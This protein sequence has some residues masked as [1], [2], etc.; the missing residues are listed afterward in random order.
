M[1]QWRN[2][3]EAEPLLKKITRTFCQ[4]CLYYIG[5]VAQTEAQWRNGAMAQWRNGAMAKWRNGAEAELDSARAGCQ[6]CLYY[7]GVDLEQ[8][9]EKVVCLYCF[10]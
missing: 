7:M 8:N 4:V 5:V 6:G 10:H 2:G 3:A 1:A 9:V